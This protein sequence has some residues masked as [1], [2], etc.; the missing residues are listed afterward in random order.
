MK[1]TSV[2]TFPVSLP[3]A[4]PMTMA[5]ITIYT[6]NNVLVKITTD[7]GI[8]GW[9]EGVEAMDVTGD[10][11]GRIK[12]SIDDLG[13]R[14]IGM[15]ARRRTAIW[16]MLTHAVTGN[17]TAIG[18]IDIALH[19]IAGKA[20]GVPVAE[21]IGG[22]NRTEIPALSLMGSGKTDADLETFKQRYDAGYRWFKLKLGMG[23]PRLELETFRG[24]AAHA[25]DLMLCGDAN[26]VWSEQVSAAFLKG[27]EGLGIR[28]I[29]QPTRS[30]DALVRLAEVSP[31]A[32]CADESAK[33]FDDILSFGGTAIAGVSL[34][35]IKH[36]GITGVMR[37]ASICD[38]MGIHVNL[39]GK[40]AES[41]IAAVANLHCAAAMSDT[42]YG[43]SPASQGLAKDITD[44]P[45]LPVNGVFTLPSGPGLGVE[46]DEDLVRSLAS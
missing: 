1:I 17:T 35:L 38:A 18:A 7:E 5:H 30:H 15:D 3:L 42:Y 12:A 36:I 26:A 14:I 25:D 9:G 29:E 22:V 34:K 13:S 8:V 43:C 31:T 32:V 20:H 4:K 37:A 46:V 19:D 28:M 16:S 44:T 24:M 11:Q 27:T 10:N 40:I 6:S 2:E 41:S 39:A 45:V 33:T 21:L 23:D